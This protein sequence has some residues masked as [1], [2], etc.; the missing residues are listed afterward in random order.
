MRWVGRGPSEASRLT[1]LGLLVMRFSVVF[2]SSRRR[3]TRFDCDWSSDVCSSDLP[4]QR[5]A[6]AFD[7]VVELAR[8]VLL[9]ALKG[10]S[11]YGVALPLKAGSGCGGGAFKDAHEDR[12]SVV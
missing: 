1:P 5:D 8:D 3:H 9:E 4:L 7:R 11:A 6:V 12:K 2:F 10:L